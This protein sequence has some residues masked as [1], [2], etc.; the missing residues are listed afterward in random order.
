L[1]AV[2]HRQPWPLRHQRQRR[3]AAAEEVG[4]VLQREMLRPR[5]R[6]PAHPP[7]GAVLV[8]AVEVPRHR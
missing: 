8:S 3:A 5:Q 1:Q 7:A 2:E 6:P 4:V